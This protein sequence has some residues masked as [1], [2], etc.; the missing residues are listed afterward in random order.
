MWERHP[1][2]PQKR[3][4]VGNGPRSGSY[5]EKKDEHSRA[6]LVRE[7]L[8]EGLAP[9]FGPVRSAAT[10]AAIPLVTRGLRP[11]YP[12]GSNTVPMAWAPVENLGELSESSSFRTTR[13]GDL[14][15]VLVGL[16]KA[17]REGG[18]PW[19]RFVA[20]GLGEV[21]DLAEFARCWPAAGPRL[22]RG[23]NWP[24]SV[25]VAGKNQVGWPFWLTRSPFV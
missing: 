3:F 24:D 20:E 21:F 10:R 17:V 5:H 7:A 19:W 1:T 14:L 9:V 4:Y 23:G 12:T 2:P 18:V 15:R 25:R 22:Y 16:S 11:L 6:L 13:T 8:Q